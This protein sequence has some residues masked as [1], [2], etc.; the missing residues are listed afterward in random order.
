MEAVNSARSWCG[1]Q[2][3]AVFPM[4]IGVWWTCSAALVFVE[5]YSDGFSAT[6]PEVQSLLVRGTKYRST[7]Y[8]C[9]KVR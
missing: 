4:F 7:Q 5:L 3:L 1:F 9:S 6:E 8:G 2:P